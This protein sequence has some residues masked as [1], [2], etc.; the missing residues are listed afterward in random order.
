MT[1][2]QLRLWVD[3]AEE[4]DGDRRASQLIDQA[5]AAQGTSDAIEARARELKPEGFQPKP[6]VPA[7]KRRGKR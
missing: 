2:A 1:R 5:I 6:K 7:K 4:L 3:Q